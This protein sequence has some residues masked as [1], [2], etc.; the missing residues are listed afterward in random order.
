MADWLIRKDT[1][2]Q[3]YWQRLGSRS[4]TERQAFAEAERLLSENP[5][6]F[7]HPVGMIKHLKAGFHC[8]H[9]YRNLP[10]AQ[11]IFYKIW[12]R[13]EIVD[14]LQRR[15]TDIPAEPKWEGDQ[16][17]GLVVFIFAGPHPKTK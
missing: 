16:Q 7:H 9:E 17:K 13:Q 6:P 15:E 11:R 8:N 12:P 10:N 5:Y 14:A 4:L 1:K 2:V 3:Q